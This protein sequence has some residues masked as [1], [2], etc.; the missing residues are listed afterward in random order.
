M[1]VALDTYT[2]ND[3]FFHQDFRN[4]AYNIAVL[5]GVVV[6][7][8]GSNYILNLPKNRYDM[9]MKIL[10]S[11]NN[12]H[13]LAL[14][15]NLDM[16]AEAHFACVQNE[17][18]HYQT[19]IWSK[20]EQQEPSITGASFIVFSGALKSTTGLNAKASLVEDGVLVQVPPNTLAQLKNHLKEMKDFTIDCGKIG[21]EPTETV[22]VTWTPDDLYF[23]IGYVYR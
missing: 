11:K 3:L 1:T 6:R 10:N 12:E 14:G 13:V 8:S 7:K 15:G 17:E 20:S 9:I 5:P 21:Q 16:T 2:E 18:G 19:Q 22:Q 23:N 4:F